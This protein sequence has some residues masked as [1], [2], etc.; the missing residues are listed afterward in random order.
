M[1]RFFFSLTL[2][3]LA[4]APVQGG[5]SGLAHGGGSYG[6][7]HGG[8]SYTGGYHSGG[9]GYHGYSAGCYSGYHGYYGGYRY[10]SYGIVSYGSYGSYGPAYASY[11]DPVDYGYSSGSYP[12]DYT[13]QEPAPTA[14]PPAPAPA[15]ITSTNPASASL[16]LGKVD[17][18]GY[19]HSP[20]TTSAFKVE[21][22]AD[23][24]TFYD[25]VTGQ[26]FTVHKAGAAPAP[27]PKPAA[28]PTTAMPAGKVDNF[29]YVHSPYSTYFIKVRSDDSAQLYHDPNTGQFFTVIPH[30]TSTHLASAQEID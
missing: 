3:A 20:F 11:G 22:Y 16:P 29:G 17:E 8:A 13:T 12:T 15:A 25:P 27:A 18:A 28:P 19:V 7:Y 5:T 4:I 9:G 6:G 1:K 24:Q 2:L 26:P 10:P 14:L 21:T 23:G 30:A